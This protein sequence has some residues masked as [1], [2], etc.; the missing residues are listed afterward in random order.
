VGFEREVEFVVLPEAETNR[1]MNLTFVIH[2]EDS[3]RKQ[4][5]RVE[6]HTGVP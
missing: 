4:R 1:R 3:W 2:H 6:R 5:G